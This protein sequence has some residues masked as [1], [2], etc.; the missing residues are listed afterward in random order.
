MSSS[1]PTLVSLHAYLRADDGRSLA[2][3]ATPP[4]PNDWDA[5]VPDPERVRTA[6]YALEDMD[7]RA[8]QTGAGVLM[9]R[10]SPERFRQVF[11]CEFAIDAGGQVRL[12]KPAH[13]PASLS[14]LVAAIDVAPTPEFY[15]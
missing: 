4:D 11:H 15:P 13:I 2:S 3:T 6:V 1:L 7:I 12:S 14:T 9:L 5:L 10:A 8:E